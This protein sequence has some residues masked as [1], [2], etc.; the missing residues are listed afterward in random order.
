MHK[1]SSSQLRA[2]LKTAAHLL[3]QASAHIK[4]VEAENAAYKRRDHATK[5]ASAIRSKNM[6]PSWGQNEDEMVEHIMQMSGE[7]IAAIEAAVD[8]AAPHDPFAYIESDEA[9]AHHHDGARVKVA[10]GSAFEQY[11][12]GNIE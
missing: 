10:G 8:M 2:T 1:V 7:K 3:K 12:L 4:A 6:S 5:L 9:E 11:V